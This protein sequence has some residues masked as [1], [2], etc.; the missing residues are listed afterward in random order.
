MDYE[1]GDG[2]CFRNLFRSFVSVSLTLLLCLHVYAYFWG[3]S[4]EGLDGDISDVRY[5]VTQLT[6]G[7]TEV[8]TSI[9]VMR[10][11]II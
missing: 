8:L 1:Y 3:P 6:R 2:G 7:L 10:T 9:L 11:Q 5:V 4:H